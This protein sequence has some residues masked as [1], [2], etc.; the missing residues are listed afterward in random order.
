MVKCSNMI[1]TTLRQLA[2]V[3]ALLIVT[4]APP[5]WA[6]EASPWDGDLRAGLRLVAGTQ[7]R[8]VGAPAG[9]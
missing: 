6:G 8:G 7:A 1:A 3:I 2:R 5:A 4:I 9:I